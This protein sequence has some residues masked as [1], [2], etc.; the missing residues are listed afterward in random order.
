[1]SKTSDP[2]KKPLFVKRSTRQRLAALV[3]S[4]RHGKTYGD[5]LRSA[6]RSDV[7]LA[8]P[9]KHDPYVR[10][11]AFSDTMERLRAMTQGVPATYDD[12]VNAALDLMLGDARDDARL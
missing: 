7:P 5:L 2:G 4:G 1:M 8:D 9:D 3:R 6:M 10:I 12:A 11:M